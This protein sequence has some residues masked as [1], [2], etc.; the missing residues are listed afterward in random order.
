M[1]VA[2]VDVLVLEQPGVQREEALVFVDSG[3]FPAEETA[4]EGGFFGVGP[5]VVLGIVGGGRGFGGRG[6][7]CC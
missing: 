1:F 2:G 3:R 6:C 4:E 7:F 5:R